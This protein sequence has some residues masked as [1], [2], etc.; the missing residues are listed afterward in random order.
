MSKPKKI[1]NLTTFE[2]DKLQ[3]YIKVVDKD[4]FNVFQYLDTFPRYFEQAAEPTIQRNTFS[5]WSDSANT[6]M[7]LLC[8]ISG[9][10]KK[11]ELV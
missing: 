7:Y 4:I 1:S 5:F 10:Q 3:Q 2:E 9:G 11:I 8:N 6:K